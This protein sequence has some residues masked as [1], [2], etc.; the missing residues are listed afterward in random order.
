MGPDAGADATG[1]DDVGAGDDAG[2]MADAAPPATALEVE[3]VFQI[4]G[5]TGS[6]PHDP[7][8]DTKGFGWW[9]DQ[10]GSRVGYWDPATGN[11]MSYATPTPNCGVH[12]LV[13]DATGNIWYT[14]QGCD[15]M[16]RIDATTREIT[17]YVVPGGGRPHTPVVL[18]GIVWFTLQGG[19]KIGR[20]D[21]A[22]P[23]AIQTFDVGPGPYGVWISPTTK[24]LWVALF[25]TNKI[26]E[27]DPAS[28]GTPKVIDLPNAGARPRRIAVDK[29][30]HV[31][32][33]DYARSR[34]GRYDPESGQ[35]A[36]W[37]TPENAQP[38]AITVG[39]PGDDRIFYGFSNRDFVAVFDPRNP[40]ADQIVVDVGV[41]HTSRHMTTD[42]ER[43]RIW[44]GLSGAQRVAYI[45]LP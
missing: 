8:F 26:V 33:T 6:A 12:G 41:Q 32:Y 31:Y 1:T 35:F 5:A 18:D 42:V 23:N 25:P 44:L 34:L 7:A 19:G 13:T 30:G 14:G 15:R 36:E 28:P 38:Y 3:K 39:P 45:Q 2:A 20:L 9:T 37:P 40:T 27:V 11:T 10:A 22:M 4:P 17:D 21:P 16:G 43:R 24:K 29:N